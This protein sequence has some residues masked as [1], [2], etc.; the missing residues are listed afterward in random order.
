MI[1]RVIISIY[2]LVAMWGASASAATISTP[3]DFQA[4]KR[5]GIG[6]VLSGATGLMGAHIHLNVGQDFSL[7]LGYGGSQDMKA[8]TGYFRHLLTNAMFSFYWTLGYARWW[9]DGGGPIKRTTPDYLYER[10]LSASEIESGKFVE[11]IIYPGIGLQFYNFGGE[12][13]GLSLYAE[14]LLMS[15]IED[16]RINP[17]LGLGAFYYF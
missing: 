9:S 11:H 5:M 6:T 4:Q 10:F 14:G 13:D 7:G 15:D 17:A 16:L 12:F 1:L 3:M 8:F 2:I